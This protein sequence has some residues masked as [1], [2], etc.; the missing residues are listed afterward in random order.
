MN[1]RCLTN[2]PSTLSSFIILAFIFGAAAACI[3]DII[4]ILFPLSPSVFIS[5]LKVEVGLHLHSR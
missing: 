5:C 3:V 2:N 1:T 4:H